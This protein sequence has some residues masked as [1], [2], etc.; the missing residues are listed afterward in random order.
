MRDRLTGVVFIIFILFFG[1]G[2]WV[3]EDREF[4]DLENRK[5]ACCPEFSVS[6]FLDGSYTSDFEK[7]MS[8]QIPFKDN[9]VT[10]KVDVMRA[11]GHRLI[12][13]VFFGRD[14]YLISQYGKPG[15]QLYENINDIKLFAQNTELPVT[16]LIVPNASEIY[17]EK[18][19]ALAACYS[20]REVIN[21]A[22]TELKDVLQFVDATDILEEHKSEG[23]YF[24]TDHHWNMKGAY[25][26]YQ[27]L[28]EALEIPAKPL[29]Q[30]TVT[31]G[32]SIFYGSLYSKAP[33]LRQV[34]D[35]LIMY[36]NPMGKYTVNYVQEAESSDD[37]F[38]R[39]KLDIKDK[40]TVFLN[41]NHPYVTVGSNAGLDENVLVLKDSYAH[42]LLPFLADTYANLEI[43]DLRY[44]HND[45]GQFI[46][47]HEI[48]RVIM[49]YNVDF[50]SSDENFLWLD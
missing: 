23:I 21:E 24:M 35:S 4:S 40:Y 43:L 31:E 16:L 45:L 34:P 27:A 41:G 38:S 30:Y 33:S 9:L 2:F 19:P 3:V 48:D 29:N 22:E 10:L 11:A 47:E 50:L 8:D 49:I 32:S 28:M 7:Y 12:N 42:A 46:E 17:Q 13:G 44:F 18:L 26:G 14:G 1:V 39:E 37:L 6:S 25:Y 36:E 20:Q 15:E 5:L